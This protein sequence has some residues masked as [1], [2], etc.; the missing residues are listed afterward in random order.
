LLTSFKVS[1]AIN[2]QLKADSVRYSEVID[3]NTSE[4]DFRALQYALFMAVF[5]E[6]VAAFF[7]LAASWKIVK[8]KKRVD[9]LALTIR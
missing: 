8:D 4:R 7:Y 3:V 2:E 6:V 5:M 1:D 9:Q